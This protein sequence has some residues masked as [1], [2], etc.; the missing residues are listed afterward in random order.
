MSL[1]MTTPTKRTKYRSWLPSVSAARAH[2]LE[3]WGDVLARQDHAKRRSI[4]HRAAARRHCKR[5][6]VSDQ[7]V[8]RCDSNSRPRHHESGC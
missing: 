2:Q 5:L 4:S 3:L 6:Q 7:L 1:Q 8:A